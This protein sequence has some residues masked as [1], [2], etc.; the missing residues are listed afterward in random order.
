MNI[1]ELA[2]LKKM[3]GSGSDGS[4]T[5]GGGL[6]IKQFTVGSREDAFAFLRNNHQKIV[7]AVLTAQ[8]IENTYDNIKISSL[9]STFQLSSI[10]YGNS[11]SNGAV[12]FTPELQM[13]EIMEHQDMT[14]LSDGV[15]GEPV[16]RTPI[17]DA[18]WAAMGAQ[19]TFYYIG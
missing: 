12:T 8:S 18:Y 1:T 5:S 14:F 10:F 11:E 2:M 7:K 6:G 4:S 13:A 3:A 9:G 17:P 19:L 16:Q 15:C